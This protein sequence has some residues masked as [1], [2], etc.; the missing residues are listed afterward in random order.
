[1]IGK[2]FITI[3]KSSFLSFRLNFVFTFLANRKIK[4][5][6]GINIPICLARKINGNFM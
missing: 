1:M 5:I 4:K 6:N 3:K 2:K